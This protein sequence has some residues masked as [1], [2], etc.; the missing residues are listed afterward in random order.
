MTDQGKEHWLTY[1]ETADL[2][3][4]SPEAVRQR[5]RRYKWPRRTP[6]EHGAVARVLG[7]G[8]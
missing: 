7:A 5:A 4:I 3:G 6:N 2:L 8:R 1:A